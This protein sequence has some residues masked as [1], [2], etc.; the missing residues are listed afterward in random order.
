MRHSALVNSASC[1]V[2]AAEEVLE[3]A[4]AA[5]RPQLGAGGAE[6]ARGDPLALLSEAKDR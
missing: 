2:S 4:E 1:L 3:L 5:A 6:E